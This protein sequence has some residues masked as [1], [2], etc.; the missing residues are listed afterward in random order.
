MGI[1]GIYKEIGPGERI[2]LSKLAIEKFEDTGRPLRI[3]I[4][5]SIWLFQ[6]QSSKGG[7]NPALRTFYY[8]LLRLISLSIHPLFVFD[9][10]NK[11]P[12][13]RNKR[14]GP[15]VASI[16]EFLA[17]QL[18]KQF[19][20]P[21]HIAP[22]EAEAECALL[23][24]EGIV[25][26]V[27]SED[28]DTLMFGSRITLRNWSPEQKSSKVPTHVNVYDAG[29]T[30]SGPSGL[31]REGMILVAL[32]SGGDYLPEGIPG[33]GPKTACEAARAGFGHR[34]CA[35]KKK[36]TAALQAWRE[37]LARELRTN[38]S[39]FFKRKH[40]TLSVPE[41]FP[42]ADILGYYVSPA[43]SSPEALERLKRNLRWDQDL[44]FAGLRTFT[45][46]AFEWVKV[47]GAKKFIRN[48][49]P[50]LLVRHL[51]MRGQAAAEGR[52]SEDPDVIEAEEGKLVTSIH[53]TRQHPSTDN[54]PELRVAF[55]P[56]DIVNIDLD[57]EE[58]D[59]EPGEDE[60]E[61]EEMALAGNCD[62]EAPKKRGPYLY[63]PT[64]LDKIWIFE[65]LVKIGAP[66]TVQDW[67]EKQRR[68][69]AP[70]PAKVTKPCAPK[71]T[72]GGMQ[73]GAMDSFT[74]I[75]KAN[76][77]LA[78][79]KRRSP[80]IDRV[81]L[82]RTSEGLE[83]EL[84]EAPMASSSRATFKPSSR[85][86]SHSV[87]MKAPVIID[88]LSSPEAP[89]QGSHLPAEKLDEH[90][91]SPNITKRIR[92]LR[93]SQTSPDLSN[94]WRS[95][96]IDDA[97]IDRRINILPP[98]NS[99]RTEGCSNNKLF[100]RYQTQHTVQEATAA[101]E[102]EEDRGFLAVEAANDAPGVAWLVKE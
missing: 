54:T 27:L 74:R 47:T 70:K 41:D 24:R 101:A 57:A 29:K 91:R 86:D 4:D 26:V 13:K 102:E 60:D 15:N 31:D 49:A 51:R 43:I 68:K 55:S 33:C 52:L 77:G 71:K 83:L 25:D 75:T 82:S 28:V 1:H 35:I 10:P 12:F 76:A 56:I 34:L 38:E 87:V 81:D 78:L 22:G 32:M 42:R 98:A 84:G 20:F 93:R 90:Y 100:T 46:D 58:P 48:L 40:G 11:P 85:P 89:C 61:E 7:T 5:T 65:T 18:L 96:Y 63:D 3:A 67:E 36:D 92:T 80:S 30:K 21:F 50:A 66:L 95:F 73:K 19:G 44:N 17:K 9:G 88:I 45:A 94:G 69:T 23:Q 6:I 72:T 14:T 2:A 53:G 8:R 39:K 59:D 62:G 16:P 97:W 99:E 64:H 37:D 79:A